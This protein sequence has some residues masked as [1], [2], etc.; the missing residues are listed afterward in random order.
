MKTITLLFSLALVAAGCAS[1]KS[2]SYEKWTYPNGVVHE[3]SLSSKTRT[4]YEG[5][6]ALANQVITANDQGQSLTIGSLG[7]EV[8]STNLPAQIRAVGDA[9]SQAQGTKAAQDAIREALR[10]KIEPPM[11]K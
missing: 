8:T 1:H 2:K 5:Q 10:K 4:V 6:S 9:Y 7:H 3:R 11:P